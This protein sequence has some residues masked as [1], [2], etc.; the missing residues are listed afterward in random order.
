MRR[1][2]RHP[3]KIASDI[4]EISMRFMRKKI[5]QSFPIHAVKMRLT[6]ETTLILSLTKTLGS[7]SHRARDQNNKITPMRVDTI[8]EGTT[9]LPQDSQLL[10][11]LKE[12]KAE[13]QDPTRLTLKIQLL[14]GLKRRI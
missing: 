7:I 13:T 10:P 4:K 3:Q 2:S 12:A 8:A 5:G 14:P 9:E 11:L 1:C 6:S